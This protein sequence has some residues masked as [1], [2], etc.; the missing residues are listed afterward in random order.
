MI[1]CH[2]YKPRRL[3]MA[4]ESM[5]SK[6]AGDECSSTLLQPLQRLRALSQ[7]RVRSDC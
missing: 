7:K 5:V 1:V 2:V 3:E 4:R 6:A